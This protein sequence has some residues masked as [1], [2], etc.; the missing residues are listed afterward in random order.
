MMKRWKS[1]I[2]ILSMLLALAAYT[3]VFPLY[4]AVGLTAMILIH[5]VGHI[6]AAKQRGIPVSAPLFIPFVGAFIAMRRNPRDAATEAYVALG[7]PM[8]GTV[9]AMFAYALGIFLKD[10]TFIV[11]ANIG[12]YLN[13]INLLPLH[14]LDGGRIATAISRWLWLAGLII[15]LIF[16]VYY[17]NIL[18]FLFWLLFAWQVYRRVFSKTRQSNQYYAVPAALRWKYGIAYASLMLLLFYLIST[19][20]YI[21]HLVI[22]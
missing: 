3:L 16:T 13:L 22:R 19:V 2:P 18:F 8:L 20:Q 11:T 7:G 5:E 12:F 21:S 1:I 4:F 6:V 9:G 10:P 15:G 17:R 14:P